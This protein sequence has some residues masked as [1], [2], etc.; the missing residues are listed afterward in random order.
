M[1]PPLCRPWFNPS[2]F[3]DLMPQGCAARPQALGLR[4]VGIDEQGLIECTSCDADAQNDECIGWVAEWSKAVVLKTFRRE[5]T[6]TEKRV[7]LGK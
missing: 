6:T 5:S 3:L 1:H 7:F 2:Q 4:R